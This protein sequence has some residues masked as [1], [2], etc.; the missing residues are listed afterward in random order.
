MKK[1]FKKTD[2]N[3]NPYLMA[4]MTAF[5][6]GLISAASGYFI[7]D[8]Q[9]KHAIEAEQYEYRLKAYMSF[10][11]KIDRKNSPFI[12]QLFAIG[13]MAKHVATDSE[14]QAYEDKTHDIL[15]KIKTEDV[16]CQLNN[17][18]SILRMFGDKKTSQYCDDILLIV[19]Y[20]IHLVEWKQYPLFVKH[21]YEKCLKNEKGIAH[22]YEARVSDEDR[23]MIIMLREIFNLLIE[24]IRHEIKNEKNGLR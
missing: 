9:A 5:L 6:A 21:I 18:F 19:N 3:P 2:K 20:K 12:S 10:L 17:D 11:E 14:I 7:S 16:Y 13:D 15:S 24:H 23:T 4:V 22:G 8:L 1:N